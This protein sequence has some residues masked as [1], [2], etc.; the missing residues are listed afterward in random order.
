M[1]ICSHKGGIGIAQVD[2]NPGHRRAKLVR[3]GC[4]N[5]IGNSTSEDFS[6]HIHGGRIADG[7]DFWEI[8]RILTS[9]AVTTVVR[10]DFHRVGIMVDAESYRLLR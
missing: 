9:Q 4:K 3:G 10:A 6:G 7:R 2:E 1:S 8:C 5:G